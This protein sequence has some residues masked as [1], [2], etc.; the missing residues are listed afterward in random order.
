MTR[1]ISLENAF[2]SH[3]IITEL[4]VLV[5]SSGFE[6]FV[7]SFGFR[8]VNMVWS[9]SKNFFKTSFHAFGLMNKVFK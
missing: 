7:Y 2:S 8:A 6:V 9:L 5:N 1:V 4:E 3:L